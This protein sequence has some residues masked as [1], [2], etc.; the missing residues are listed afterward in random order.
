ML[1]YFTNKNGKRFK[2]TMNYIK[3]FS[4]IFDKYYIY[5]ITRY[6]YSI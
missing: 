5:Y 6:V 2:I 1:N 3:Y 4:R